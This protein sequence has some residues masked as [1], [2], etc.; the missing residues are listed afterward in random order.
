MKNLTVST[1]KKIKIEKKAIHSLVSKLSKELDF[2]IQSL[3]INFIDTDLMIKI[4]TEYLNHKYD[5]DI[6]TFNYSGDNS[7]LDGEIFISINEAIKNSVIFDVHLD[8]EIVRLVIHGILHLLGYDDVKAS[9]RKKMKK[10]E[11]KYTDLFDKE[12]KNIMIEYE[13]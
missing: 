12:F 5:T 4:N 10:E 13:Y 1:S 7:N 8:S 9:D 2:T 11:N 3:N 6:L